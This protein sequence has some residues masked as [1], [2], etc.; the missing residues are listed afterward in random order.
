MTGANGNTVEEGTLQHQVSALSTENTLLRGMLDHLETDVVGCV[1]LFMAM[2][3]AV[4][5]M[6]MTPKV[7]PIH[8]GILLV[9]PDFPADET[10]FKKLD[11]QEAGDWLHEQVEAAMERDPGRAVQNIRKLPQIEEML[12]EIDWE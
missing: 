1:K 3:L 12:A 11:L 5:V 4:S 9:Y 7:K 8:R 6:G 10:W 2:D